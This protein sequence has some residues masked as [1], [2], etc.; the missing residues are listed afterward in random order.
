MHWCLSA[1][2]LLVFSCAGSCLAIS[3]LLPSE[4]YELY[5][6]F[7]FSELILKEKR[8]Q[9][10]IRERKTKTGF[11]G[12]SRNRN[13]WLPKKA[14]SFIYYS[15]CK[16]LSNN[17]RYNNFSRITKLTVMVNVL[18]WVFIVNLARNHHTLEERFLLFLYDGLSTTLAY[19]NLLVNVSSYLIYSLQHNALCGWRS[20]TQC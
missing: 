15:S 7:I 3:W 1:F 11:V 5:L 6:R 8:V 12:R 14:Y 17:I 10:L 13:T 19:Q 18:I 20:D 4:S 16:Y 2:L 9:T